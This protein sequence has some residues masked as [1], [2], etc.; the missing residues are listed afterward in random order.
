MPAPPVQPDGRRDAHAVGAAPHEKLIAFDEHGAIG[1]ADRNVRPQHDRRR[2]QVG[3]HV[4]RRP[5]RL[6]VLIEALRQRRQCPGCITG[7]SIRRLFGRRRG[8]RCLRRYAYVY[9]CDLQLQVAPVCIGGNYGNC[10]HHQ[11]G[12]ESEIFKQRFQPIVRG[13]RPVKASNAQRQWT[14]PPC[15][16]KNRRR[17][18]QD[19]D[20]DRYRWEKRRYRRYRAVRFATAAQSPVAASGR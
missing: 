13:P 9:R 6:T 12:G 7:K 4:F 16:S 20:A 15:R 2:G 8:L 3:E 1:C 14:N 11:Y 18:R 19:R 5:G 17:D 10:K